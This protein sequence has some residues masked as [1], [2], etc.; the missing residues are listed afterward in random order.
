MN[1]ALKS[2]C[3]V[4]ARH[5][6]ASLFLS[7]L[8]LSGCGTS[9]YDEAVK[10]SLPELERRG[11]FAALGPDYVR[12]PAF[13]IAFRVPKVFLE[14]DKIKQ[15]WKSADGK[16]VKLNS[17]DPLELKNDPNFVGGIRPELAI[18]PE[19]RNALLDQAHQGTY[20]CEYKVTPAEDPNNPG[21][22]SSTGESFMMSIWMF[23]TSAQSRVKPPND[24]ALLS[25]VKGQGK[26]AVKSLA[27]EEDV[28]EAT[29]TPEN[30][31]P[32]SITAKLARFPV[33]SKFMV[34]RDINRIPV[35]KKGLVRL[36][37]FRL[38]KYQVFLALRI[39]SDLAEGETPEFPQDAENPNADRL[40]DIGRAVIGT[41]TVIEDTLPKED[42]KKK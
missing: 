35:E 14:D 39:S 13:P 28:I 32:P 10:K 2:F 19:F 5:V 1:L 7:L 29:P 34:S 22:S 12:F 16:A 4:S 38:D 18:P 25:L 36:W 20:F 41:M 27:W 42:A 23:D 3:L 31:S 37:S 26:V 24:L 17:K 33:T 30:P 6:I 8:V 11:K 40:L 9:T 15:L 21:S